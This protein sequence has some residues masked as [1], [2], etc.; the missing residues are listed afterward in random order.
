MGQ[1]AE[2]GLL[3]VGLIFDSRTSFSDLLQSLESRWGEA[4]F[5]SPVWDFSQVTDYYAEEMGSS[6][7]RRFVVFDRLI[8][9]V[10]L[11]GIKHKA[12]EIED[13]Y[14][15]EDGGRTVNVDPGFLSGDKLLLASHKNHYHRI[16]L[17][18]GVFVELTLAFCRGRWRALEWTYPDFRDIY[19]DWFT[20][21]REGVR[22]RILSHRGQDV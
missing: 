17:G 16:Y 10:D 4:V 5:L 15:R 19:V 20:S 6:L 8:I 11:I 7:L 14:R 9:P 13:T 2:L 22:E 3:I 21:I 18:E 12:G 1:R